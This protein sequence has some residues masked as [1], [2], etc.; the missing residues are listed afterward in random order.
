LSGDAEAFVP[1]PVHLGSIAASLPA[2]LELVETP[3]GSSQQ[4]TAS[5]TY[6]AHEQAAWSGS[7]RQF[8]GAAST[9]PARK[10][11]GDKIRCF[12]RATNINFHEPVDPKVR[13]ELAQ[14]FGKENGKTFICGS[15]NKLA[16]STAEVCKKISVNFHTGASEEEAWLGWIR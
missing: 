5:L 3:H 9:Y 6:D 8:R 16:Q 10:E 14:L 12:T 7:D 4:L 2:N 13:E 1:T 15:T 11:P